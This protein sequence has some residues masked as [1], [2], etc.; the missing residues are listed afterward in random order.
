MS[1]R[2]SIK[3]VCRLRPLNQ[4][5]LQGNFKNCVEHDDLS[6][7]INVSIK[8]DYVLKCESDTK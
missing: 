2:E 7:T 3:V 8:I 4:I 5:E 6:I 1:S